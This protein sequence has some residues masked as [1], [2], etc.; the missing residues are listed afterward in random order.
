MFEMQNTVYKCV[1]NNVNK[2]V[3]FMW[4]E[5]STADQAYRPHCNYYNITY[6]PN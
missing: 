6:I 4:I 2:V 3:L 5:R 1:N